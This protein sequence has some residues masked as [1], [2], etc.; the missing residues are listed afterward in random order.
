MIE[1]YEEFIKEEYSLMKKKLPYDSTLYSLYKHFNKNFDMNKFTYENGDENSFAY[2][3][4]RDIIDGEDVLIKISTNNY[5]LKVNHQLID[6]YLYSEE[7]YNKLK[8]LFSEKERMKRLK[9]KVK[10]L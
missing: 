4:Y 8:F 10:E 1:K 6:D 9:M 3:V 5:V 2:Y 7:A